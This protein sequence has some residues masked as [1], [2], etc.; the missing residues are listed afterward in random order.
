[1]STETSGLPPERLAKVHL[2]Y[3]GKFFT[4]VDPRLATTSAALE[5]LT[6]Y[7]AHEHVVL[8]EDFYPHRTPTPKERESWHFFIDQTIDAGEGIISNFPELYSEIIWRDP[9][10]CCL[11]RFLRA[12]K[13]N[14]NAHQL[15]MIPIAEDLLRLRLT[16]VN[17]SAKEHGIFTPSAKYWPT[18]LAKIYNV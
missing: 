16:E 3:E 13:T 10:A 9:I 18:I 15:T 6:T 17:D 2:L 12:D 14:L 4:N 7:W 5:C 8:T 11:D 1:M